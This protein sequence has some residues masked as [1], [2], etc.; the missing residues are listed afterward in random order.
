MN[1]R[2]QEELLSEIK[3]FKAGAQVLLNNAIDIERKLESIDS[4]AFI[5][6][7]K[8]VLTDEELMKMR[9]Q[10]YA[11]RKIPVKAN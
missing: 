1:K 10:A 4:P 3:R 5:K 7:N 8:A 11:R 9:A 2:Q 6:K